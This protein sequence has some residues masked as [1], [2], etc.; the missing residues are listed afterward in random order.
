MIVSQNI[1]LTEGGFRSQNSYVEY[2]FTNEPSLSI[3]LDHGRLNKIAEF[4]YMGPLRAFVEFPPPKGLDML[5]EEI[6]VCSGMS[7]IVEGSP[8]MVGIVDFGTGSIF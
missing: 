4:A 5:A 1:V 2:A 3:N 8:V 7:G 6:V